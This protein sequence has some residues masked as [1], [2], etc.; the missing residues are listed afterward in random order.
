MNGGRAVLPTGRPSHGGGIERAQVL[1]RPQLQQP[2]LLHDAHV[3][4]ALGQV[5]VRILLGLDGLVPDGGVA[6]L[7]VEG[8]GRTG[9]KVVPLEVAHGHVDGLDG[10]GIQDG[11]LGPGLEGGVGAVDAA[12]AHLAHG[13]GMDRP[14]GRPT[15]V[16]VALVGREALH[17]LPDETELGAEPIVVGG[18]VQGL[19]RRVVG[20]IGRAVVVANVGGWGDGSSWGGVG[21][22]IAI[23]IAIVIAIDIGRVVWVGTDGTGTNTELGTS[24][25]VTRDDFHT[26]AAGSSRRT[27]GRGAPRAGGRRTALHRTTETIPIARGHTTSSTG[28][29][30]RRR[31]HG[32]R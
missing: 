24:S 26:D 28:Y 19:G 8:H 21:I 27:S 5:D 13:G 20:R 30:R 32:R 14:T 10:L 25:S 2:A 12:D 16:D 22:A 18:A 6:L 7:D 17:L 1:L 4:A 15:L 23:A 29:P 3:L 31:C 9:Q 11:S